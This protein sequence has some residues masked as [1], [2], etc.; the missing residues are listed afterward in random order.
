MGSYPHQPLNLPSSEI[1]LLHLQAASTLYAPIICSLEIVSLDK[2][3]KYEA[4]SYT[5]GDEEGSKAIQ[6]HGKEFVVQENLRHALRRLRKKNAARKIWIDALC[7]NQN[8]QA[9]KQAQLPLMKTI[10]E[11]AELVNVWLGEETT[12]SKLALRVMSSRSAWSLLKVGWHMHWIERSHG[13][14]LLPV[15]ERLSGFTQAITASPLTWEMRCGEINE[16]INRPWWKRAWIVQEVMLARKVVLLCGRD[17]ASWD[18]VPKLRRSMEKDETGGIAFGQP[19]DPMKWSIRDEFS[20]TLADLRKRWAT[21]EP[22]VN[23]YE[24]LYLL[25]SQKCKDPR[26]KIYAYLGIIKDILDVNIVPNYD[27]P[28]EVVYFSTTRDIIASTGSLDILNCKRAWSGIPEDAKDDIDDSTFAYSLIER[29][30]FHD[31]HCKVIAD[32]YSGTGQRTVSGWVQLP[33]GWERIENGKRYY[34]WNTRSYSD[35]SPLTGK[36][37][38]PVIPVADQRKLPRGWKKTWDNTGRPRVKFDPHFQ[39]EK[40]E[41][42]DPVMERLSETL[43]S[44]CPNW[45]VTTAWDPK[46]LM[47]WANPEPGYFASGNSSAVPEVGENPNVLTL[48]GIIFDHISQRAPSL[49]TADKQI[50]FAMRWYERFKE[51]DEF[52]SAEVSECP[53]GGRSGRQN[54]YWRCLIG[55]YAGDRAAP[56]RD[57]VLLECW[58]DKVGWSEKEVNTP[59]TEVLWGLEKNMYT[60]YEGLA[61]SRGEV[62]VSF[63]IVEALKERNRVEKQYGLYARRILEV[64]DHRT[65]FISSKGYL[66]M[67]PWNCQIGDVVTVLDGG[68]TPYLLRPTPEGHHMELIGEVYVYGIMGGE[69]MEMGLEKE[70]VHII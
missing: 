25:R 13:K 46:P 37:P 26:D 27:I 52:V 6:L 65:L 12:S 15:R 61:Q 7:I 47:D 51:W 62:T 67:A 42:I 23:V 60:C 10:Y 56:Q 45:A 69:V 38:Q 41:E 8:D 31:T 2:S 44:W 30:K 40:H 58:F 68:K 50:P 57:E 16:L 66:G 14:L 48:Q 54:A 21:G 49:H 5:W 34:D 1:R 63:H 35:V 20:K 39:G 24:L 4:L 59:I 3:P 18:H 64:C 36:E 17:V 55:D 11:R 9:E 70:T 28:L 32:H 19:Y 33:L 43:P 22:A 29:A 53:Y